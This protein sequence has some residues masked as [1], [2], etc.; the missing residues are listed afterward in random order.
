MSI[1]SRMRRARIPAAL[2]CAS[3]ILAA[4]QDSVVAPAGPSSAATLGDPLAQ[5][6]AD[7]GFRADMIV[8]AGNH[9]V[10]EGDIIFQKAALAGAPRMSVSPGGSG[11]LFHYHTTNLVPQSMMAQGIPVN[12]SA[13][14]GNAGWTTAVRNAIAAWNGTAATKIK[15]VE[16]TSG[17]YITF[18]FIP[19]SSTGPIAVASYPVNGYPGG[20]VTINPYFNNLSASQKLNAMVHELGHTIGN[21][22]TDYATLDPTGGSQGAVHI[23]G[24]PT[25]SESAS[26]MYSVNHNW[27]GFTSN[28]GVANRYMYP[29]HAPVITSQG[30]DGS[31]NFTISWNAVT[32]AS[33]YRIWYEWWFEEWVVDPFYYPNGGYYAWTM[34]HYTITTTSSTT[35][36]DPGQ[37]TGAAPYD[38]SYL[39]TPIYPNGK[40]GL[41]V[42]SQGVTC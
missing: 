4:C 5:R 35:Y 39:I 10:V 8:D 25:G 2:L 16:V 28:D 17:A 15:F 27:N 22:H 19:S 12:L 1:T 3:A 11:P 9:F 26:V 38:C 42:R 37:G 7:M 23:T 21:R 29:V 36:S 41:T 33:Q 24:T 34:S 6:I 31:G 30:Y 32:D 20:A 14:T 13:I 18:S 40:E